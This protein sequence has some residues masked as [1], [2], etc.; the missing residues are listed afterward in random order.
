MA[1]SSEAIALRGRYNDAYLVGRATVG[2]GTLFKGIG[3]AMGVLILLGSI[4]AIG[5]GDRNLQPVG[6]AGIAFGLFVGAS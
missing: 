3:V 1:Q 4:A 2:V 6:F 5:S